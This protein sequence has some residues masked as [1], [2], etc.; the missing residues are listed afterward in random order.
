MISAGEYGY[1]PAAYLS[2]MPGQYDSKENV[3]STAEIPVPYES[4]EVEVVE[5][6]LPVQ[7]AT[8]HLSTSTSEQVE[9]SYTSD[10]DYY[11]ESTS[12]NKPA[13]V[14]HARALY[15]YVATNSEEISF[16]AGDIIEIIDDS[17]DD[18]WWTGK[19]KAGQVG[20]FPSM[21]VSEDVDEEDE[22]DEGDEEDDD[23]DCEG[24][25]IEETSLAPSCLPPPIA[26]PSIT[27]G[28]ENYE[29]E[30]DF[31]PPPAPPVLPPPPPSLPMMLNAPQTVVIQPTPEIECRPA[32]GSDLASVEGDEIQPDVQASECDLERGYPGDSSVLVS[33]ALAAHEISQSITQ[34]AMDE[35]L[36]EF[37]RRQSAASTSTSLTNGDVDFDCK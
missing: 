18:G 37:G 29:E 4:T 30:I 9:Y 21:L 32:L 17:S 6:E 14:V 24:D 31:P 26:I 20:H 10:A 19:N 1:V 35:G 11:S 7:P 12:D 25:S 5:Y 28:E 3:S 2:E 36:K 34:Q 33:T 27:S 23:E 15:P 13:G 16:D 8:Q 22:E